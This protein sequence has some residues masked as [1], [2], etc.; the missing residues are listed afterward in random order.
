MRAGEEYNQDD[1]AADGDQ[2]GD[3]LKATRDGVLDYDS[4]KLK[5]LR[6]G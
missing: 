6:G 2:S 3:D 1:P 5:V 4:I